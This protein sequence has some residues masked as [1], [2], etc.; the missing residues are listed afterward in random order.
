M[1]RVL[2]NN[3]GFNYSIETALEQAGTDWVQLEPNAIN[4][5]GA[6][7]TTVARSPISKNRQ[8]RKGVSTDLDSAVEFESDLTVSAFRDFIEGFCFANG[9]NTEVSQL[10]STGAQTVDDSYIGLTALT[11]AQADKFEVDTLIWVTGGTIA[12]NNGLKTVDADIAAAATV[13]TVAED[14]TDET[15]AFKVSFAGYRIAAGST[16]SWT[17]DAGAKQATLAGVVG[18]GTA[19]QALDLT[20]GQLVHIGSVASLGGPIQAAFENTGVNDTYGYARVVSFTADSVVFD[21]VDT[22]LQVTIASEADDVHIMFGEFIRNVSVDNN[23]F[24]ERSFT[25]EASFPN[26]GDGTVGN[27]DE[28][29]EYSKGNYCDSV[30]F[31]LPLTDKA[32]ITYGFLGTDTDKPTTT[33]KT[34]ADSA[35]QPNLTGAFSTSTD[36]ARLRLT[37]ADEDGLSTDFKNLVFTIANGVS[38]QKCI[39]NLGAQAMNFGNLEINIEAQLLFTNPNVVSAIRDNDTLTMDFVMKND[40][41]VIGI[42]VPSMTLGGGGREFPVNESVLINTEAEA[43]EDTVLGTSIGVSIF[44]VP[45]P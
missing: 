3:V 35:V 17:W 24:L 10:D 40:D 32:T 28:S 29:Y 22:L 27:T 19:L 1:G 7:V 34:G 45:L 4:N 14:L 26:L 33:R 30:S 31:N 13:I 20:P 44:P 8:R 11:S 2:T 9:I 15:A 23:D 21:K 41:G 42:D 37:E 12:A 16:P 5:F 39:G 36:I 18:L 25:M 43:F 38:A 6:D